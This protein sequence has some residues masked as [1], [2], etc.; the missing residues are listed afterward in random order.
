VPALA[1]LGVVNSS[2]RAEAVLGC[3]E[4][5]WGG[6]VGI[7]IIFCLIRICLNIKLVYTLEKNTQ[8]LQKSKLS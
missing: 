1:Q 2:V 3:A 6:M 4:R 7:S 5:E 8:V